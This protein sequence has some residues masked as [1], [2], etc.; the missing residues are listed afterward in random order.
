MNREFGENYQDLDE[1]K[2][3]GNFKRALAQLTLDDAVAAV[4]RAKRIAAA[5]EADGRRFAEHCTYCYCLDNPA[6][7]LWIV[8]EKVLKGAGVIQE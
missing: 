8:I 1:Y 6:T 2:H 3:E 5:N 4:A 7:D